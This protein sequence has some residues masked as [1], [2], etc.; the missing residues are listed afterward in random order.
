MQETVVSLHQAFDTYPPDVHSI[1]LS[2]PLLSTT[3]VTLTLLLNEP[4]ASGRTV[5]V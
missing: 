3:L 4:R 5:L 1:F 2:Q